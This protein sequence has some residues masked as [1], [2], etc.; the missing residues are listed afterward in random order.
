MHWETKIRVTCFTVIFALLWWWSGTQTKYLQGMPVVCHRFLYMSETIN[1]SPFV[2]EHCIHI[3]A[4]LH[5]SGSLQLYLSLNF[6][7]TQ[8]LSISQR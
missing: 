7:L 8:H 6:Q 2:K 3:V 4:Y 5:H 1:L